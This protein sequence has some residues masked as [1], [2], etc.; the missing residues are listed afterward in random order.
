MILWFLR[1]LWRLAIGIDM[2]IF[3][4]FLI[5]KKYIKTVDYNGL[6]YKFLESNL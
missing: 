6:F 3:V 1:I 4:D 2:S 5:R